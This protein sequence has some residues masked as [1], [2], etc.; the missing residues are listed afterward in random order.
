MFN[1]S[2]F[3][4]LSPDLYTPVLLYYPEESTPLSDKILRLK[5]SLSLVLAYFYPLAGRARDNMFVECNDLGAKFL[6][7]DVNCTLS[8]V[9]VCP[10]LRELKKL[11]PINVETNEASIGQ[12]LLVQANSFR[13]GGLVLAI[14]ISHKIADGATIGNFIRSWANAAGNCANIVPPRHD[15]SI[16][17]PSMNHW[18]G[19]SP[20]VLPQHKT[21]TRRYVFDSSKVDGLVERTSTKQVGRPTRVEV[22][23]ALLWKCMVKAS[24]RRSGVEWKRSVF[25]HTVNLRPKMFPPIPENTFGNLV[26]HYWA[27]MREEEA[28]EIDLQEL[29]MRLRAEKANYL[30]NYVK[31]E[32]VGEKIPMGVLADA[33]SIHELLN[34]KEVELYVCSS[35][36]GFPYYETDFGWG[37][38]AWLSVVSSEYKNVIWMADARGG[39]GMEV[40]LT[41]GE[42][43]MAELDKEALLMEYANLNPSISW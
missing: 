33:K 18:M 13:C 40:W 23:S 28:A 2:I 21:L 26:G 12:L 16:V 5:S 4:Q 35:W 39:E 20:L 6:E 32:L 34:N 30:E 8:E 43:H 22:V 38:P 25:L 14:S 24:T 15:A 11:L 42:D 7:A 19:I 31:E 10:C 27:E 29:V 1:L 9:L 37:K 17:A 41:L 36:C 3:D